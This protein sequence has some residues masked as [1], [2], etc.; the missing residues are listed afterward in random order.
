M[1]TEFVSILWSLHFA[2]PQCLPRATSDFNR[3]LNFWNFC[4]SGY[5]FFNPGVR[6]RQF[7]QVEMVLLLKWSLFVWIRI[8]NRSFYQFCYSVLI[9]FWR[10]Q[11]PQ[12]FFLPWSSWQMIMYMLMIATLVSE[13]FPSS[14]FLFPM[15]ALCQDDELECANHEC[16][17]HERWC[18]GEADC[19]DS[20]DEWDCGEPRVS[21]IDCP[22]EHLSAT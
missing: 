17:S 9:P 10:P 20:S 12:L 18:D 3:S 13:M 1:W 2:H 16:V 21:A 6:P 5:H 14:R 22:L 8:Y 19:L 7:S 15:P 11:W 4:C